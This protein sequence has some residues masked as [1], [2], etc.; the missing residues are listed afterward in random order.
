M[1]KTTYILN[2]KYI[3]LICK[4]LSRNLRTELDLCLYTPTQTLRA[5]K[6]NEKIKKWHNYILNDY[7]PPISEI[8]LF[9]PCAA[10]KPWTE[11]ITRSKNYQIVYSLLNQMNFRDSIS[12]HTIS[13]PLGIVGEKDYENMPFYDNPGLLQWF[14][15]KHKLMWDNA[16]YIQCINNLGKI[17]GL[18]LKKYQDKF[19]K[20]IA[21]VKPE[22][23]HRDMIEAAKK[24]ITT[25]IIIGPKKLEIR[26]IK[27]NY[28]WMAN[29]SVQDLFRIYLKK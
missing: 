10:N 18:F 17:I 13:E 9:F 2:G 29:K 5:L 14:T 4:S 21:F 6:K 24:Y 25:D 12:L 7:E 20:I 15:R 3:F 11:G 26:G 16:A 8:L 22:S 19:E 23:T 27:N 1:I 28:I